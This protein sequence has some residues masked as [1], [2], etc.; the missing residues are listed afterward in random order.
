M[1]TSRT[2]AYAQDVRGVGRF[3]PLKERPFRLLFLARTGSSVGDSLIPVAL[4]FAVIGI[5]G[6]FL[7]LGAVL[8]ARTIALGASTIA[9]GVWADRLPRRAVMISADLLRLATEAITAALLF[10]GTTHVW[11]LAVLQSAAG[12]GAG[13]FGPASTALLPQAVSAANLQKANSLLSMAE[14]GTR[15]FGPAL[16]G[17]IVASAGAGWCFAI[18]AASFLVSVAFVTSM[19]V[20]E[21]VRPL[22][23][24]FWHEVAEGWHEVRRHRW[25]TAGFLG[26]ALGNVGIGIYLVLGPFVAKEDLG[27]AVAWGMIILSIP[28]GG[29][30]G[31]FVAYRIRPT[32]PVATA[33]AIWSLAAVLP[34]AL[35]R[36]LP[37]PAI[38]VGSAVLGACLLIGNALWETAMQ[39]E[40]RP[41]RLARVASIDLLLS[42]GLMPIGQAL[43]GAL[44]AGVGLRETLLL[45]G[46]L[47][48]VPN[49]LVVA[50]VREVRRVE[51]RDEPEPPGPTLSPSPL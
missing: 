36:P 43:A 1:V 38:M 3:G 24:R 31:G 20:L 21:H 41:D 6:G 28:V 44:A 19:E 35:V 15:I 12:V 46:V 48:C 27:G 16:S 49:L 32:H 4:A 14:S 42:V 18:D 37:L 51:R 29:L 47:M 9:G 23:Q 34:F 7:G 8:G 50:C 2:R 33:F 13:F 45:A 39:Q 25:L 22:R 40:V 30:L 17:L 26:F 10:T 5:H 11:E